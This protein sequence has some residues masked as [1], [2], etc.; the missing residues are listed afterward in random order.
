PTDPP[1][2][3]RPGPLGRG[4]HDAALGGPVHDPV[5]GHA[6]P[7]A[8]GEGSAPAR[9]P[10]LLARHDAPKPPHEVSAD[11]P[12]RGTALLEAGKRVAWLTART[13][14]PRVRAL[15]ASRDLLVVPMPDDPPAFATALYA[16]LHAIDRRGLD[17]IIVDEPPATEPW[18]AVADRLRRAATSSHSAT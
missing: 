11:A 2:I 8:G 18:H 4:Q 13:D 9:S 1:P 14:D 10:G 17:T 3:P 6:S 5:A 15:A 7:A 12:T 16:T